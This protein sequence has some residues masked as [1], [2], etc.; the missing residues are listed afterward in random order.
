MKF[1]QKPRVV[2]VVRYAVHWTC[3]GKK[4]VSLSQLYDTRKLAKSAADG[5]Q[6]QSDYYAGEVKLTYG[7][8]KVECIYI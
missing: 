1:R 4:E 6:S 8:T 2:E 5:L 7:V 3:H